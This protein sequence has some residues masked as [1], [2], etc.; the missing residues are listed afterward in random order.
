MLL[1]LVLTLLGCSKG[2]DR[3]FNRDAG[4]QVDIPLPPGLSTDQ[5]RA[6]GQLIAACPGLISYRQ[7]WV[8]E[9]FSDADAGGV[10]E[11]SWRMADRLVKVPHDYYATGHICTARIGG[12]RAD[13]VS[14]VK[15]PCVNVCIDQPEPVPRSTFI[16]VQ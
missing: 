15:R 12:N 14:V 11:I 6:V 8:W 13:H 4:L 2:E 1:T 7:E 5:K 3:T 9:R 10:V 16:D